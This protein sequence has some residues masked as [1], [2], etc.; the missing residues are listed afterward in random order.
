MPLKLNVT[1]PEQNNYNYN[2]TE[3]WLLSLFLDNANLS[4]IETSCPS[5]STPICKKIH[6]NKHVI[7]NTNMTFNSKLFDG[8]PI[9]D[10][11][12]CYPEVLVKHGSP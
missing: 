12:T 6:G 10:L 4:W 9:V 3:Q 8:N 7:L 11:S 5:C 1:C 2:C